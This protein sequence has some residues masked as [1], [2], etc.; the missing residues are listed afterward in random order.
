[1][2]TVKD[3]RL[4]STKTEEEQWMYMGLD[5]KRRE[6]TD[7]AVRCTVV[8]LLKDFKQSKLAQ[9]CPLSQSMISYIANAKYKASISTEKCQEFGI[10]YEDFKIQRVKSP[11]Q[12]GEQ[13]NHKMS[14]HTVEEVPLLRNWFLGCQHPTDALL[15]DYCNVLNSLGVRSDGRKRPVE[16]AHLKNWWKNERAK[17]RRQALVSCSG[18]SPSVKQER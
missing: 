14:F 5:N 8:E 13:T 10:W 6:W 2:A 11:G 12:I 17:H 18:G 9:I 16:L 15:H 3:G 4:S 1:M 7:Q